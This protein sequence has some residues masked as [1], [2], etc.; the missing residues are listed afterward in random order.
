MKKYVVH[1]ETLKFYEYFG[2]KITKIHRGIEFVESAWLKKYI[3]LNTELRKNA[4]NDF[5]KDFFKAMN[6]CVFGKIMQNTEKY[7]DI[8][9]LSMLR[10]L[11]LIDVR[12][13]MKISLPFT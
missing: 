9:L 2:L 8:K 7:V 1:Y 6:N 12:Y 3:D 11:I 13:L 10:N 5:E 4:N